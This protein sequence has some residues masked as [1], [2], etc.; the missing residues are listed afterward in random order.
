MQKGASMNPLRIVR[1]A[2]AW[3]A[4]AASVSA[5]TVTPPSAEVKGQ[6][7][8]QGFSVVLVLGESQSTTI[9]DNVPL[10]ARKALADMKDFLPYRGYRLLDAAWILGSQRSS[11]R[12]RGP[13]EQEYQLTVVT[14][15][16]QGG[17]VQVRFQLQEPGPAIVAVREADEAAARRAEEAA[18]HDRLERMQRDAA[19]MRQQLGE[20]HASVVRAYSEIEALKQRAATLEAGPVRPRLLDGR[21]VIDTS[22]TMEIGET[23]VVGTSRVRGGDKALIAL[24]TAVPK[25]TSG[26]RE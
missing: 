5:Q 8:P 20:R 2:V 19:A 11:S 17:R 9:A 7:T 10:A 24:L 25:G 18:I 6:P 23:V 26:R 3:A 16:Q 12:L 14:V 4:L 13:D 1:V 21:S 22:F 15:L